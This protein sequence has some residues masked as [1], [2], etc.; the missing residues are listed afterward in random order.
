M[1]NPVKRNAWLKEYRK[2]TTS[3]VHHARAE[4][5]YAL[6]L[7]IKV[8]THYCGGAIRCM[9][10]G[11]HTVSE[12]FLQ[13]DHIDGGGRYHKQLVAGSELANAC[14]FGL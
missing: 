7:K 4:K 2:T 14:G 13:I 11:C 8:L 1:R 10:P 3:R 6:K 5:K 9:C 12:F